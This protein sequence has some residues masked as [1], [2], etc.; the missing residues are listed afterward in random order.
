MGN[1][2]EF[3]RSFRR[4]PRS[5]WRT[6]AITLASI[7]T[8]AI[9]MG[10]TTAIFSVLYGVVLRPLPFRDPAALVQINARA[11]DGRLL[12]MSQVEL[13]DWVSQTSLF[14]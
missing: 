5:L 12:G 2:A 4:A 14:E 10:A 3:L 11:E 9:A 6:P 8:L 7:A 1:V 13:T